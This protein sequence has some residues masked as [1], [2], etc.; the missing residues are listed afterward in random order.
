[1]PDTS[2]A[3]D[4]SEALEIKVN[5]FSQLTLN[6]VLVVNKLSEAVDFFFSKVTHLSIRTDISLRD[7]LLA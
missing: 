2:V 3:P 4:L 5:F 1:M 7:N 6:P